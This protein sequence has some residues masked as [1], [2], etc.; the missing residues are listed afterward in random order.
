MVE[1][2]LFLGA[3]AIKINNAKLAKKYYLEAFKISKNIK[4]FMIY[5]SCFFSSKFVIKLRCYFK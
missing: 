5:I 4:P 3:Q 1:Q 2:F